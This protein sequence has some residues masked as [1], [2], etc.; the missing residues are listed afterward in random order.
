MQPAARTSRRQFLKTAALA[1]GVPA[2]IPASALGAAG[3]SAPGNRIAVAV[4]GLGSRGNDHLSAFLSRPDAQV[5]A[6]SDPQRPKAEAARQRVEKHYGQATASGAYKGCVVT[7]DFREIVARPD[8]D[9]VSI[10]SPEHWHALHSLAA[11]R[12]G[13]D[14]YCE[15]ALTLTVAEGRAVCDAVR[16]YGRVFQLGTQQRSERGFR[17]AW[18][19]DFPLLEWNDEESC[20]EAMHHPFTSPVDDDVEKLLSDNVNDGDILGNLRAKAYD[21]VLNGWELGS[22]SVRIHRSDLQ[23]EIFSLLGI[24]DATARA[25]FGFLLEGL[26]AGAPPHGGIALG[27]DRL[28]ALL[29]GTS[30]IRD[31]IAFPKTAKGTCL[32]TDSPS[33]VPARQLRELHIRLRQKVETQVE[34]GKS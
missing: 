24:D 20:F 15:K 23:Q 25:R 28:V 22:G 7:Q 1:L 30:S 11:L 4:I 12:A 17:F 34:I 5:L 29:C 33:T 26:R 8:V 13:K 9:A 21:L 3:R 31:V 16:R 14:V 32:M 6:V 27:F 19:V 18:V 10:A 2:V